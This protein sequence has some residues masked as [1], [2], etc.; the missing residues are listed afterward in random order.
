MFQLKKALI[1]TPKQLKEG[2]GRYA[3]AAFGGALPQIVFDEAL[4]Y[5]SVGAA[6]VNKTLTDLLSVCVT[7]A[8][9]AYTVE[10]TVC[11]TDARFQDLPAEAYFLKT[12]EGK[13]TL[14]GKDAAGA[15]YALMTFSQMVFMDG[16]TLTVPQAEIL[17]YPDFPRRG[18]SI[19]SRYGTELMTKDEWFRLIDYFSALKQNDVEIVI[20]NC[21]GLQ[22][23][24]VRT[25]CLYVPIKKYP[26]LKTPKI[27]K[28]YSVKEKKWVHEEN[29]LPPMFEE[30]FFGELVA[31]AKERNVTVRPFVNSLGHNSLIP[32]VFPEISA[33]KE[34]GEPANKGFCTLN[35]KTYEV[36]FSIYDEII[37]RYLLPNGVTEMHV[38]LDEVTPKYRCNCEKCKAH[39]HKDLMLDYMIR[40]CK[41]L[42]EKGMKRVFMCFDMLF[43]DFNIVN[44]ELKQ[45]FIDEDIYDVVVLD[46]WAYQDPIHLFR[47]RA[48]EVNSLFRSSIKAYTGYYHWTL[49][50]DNN[51]N[52]RACVKLAKKLGFEAVDAY[53]SWEDCQDKNYLTLADVSWNTDNADNAAEF[54][55][56]YAFRNYPHNIPGALEAFR[57]MYGIMIDETREAYLN[58]A[59][60]HLDYYFYCYQNEDAPGIKNFPGSAY[61]YIEERKEDYLPYLRYLKEKAS[62]ALEFFENSGVSSRMNDIWRLSAWQYYVLADEYLTLYNLHFSYNKGEADAHTVIRELERLITQREALMLLAENTRMEATKPTY[63]RNMSVFRQFMTDLLS[64]FRRELAAGRTP[65]LDM[66]DLTYAT[67]DMLTFLQ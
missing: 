6:Y 57:A 11:P 1:P 28:Y 43:Y 21:W 44:E 22:Y 34:S 23:D 48:D 42:K 17:D 13:A 60:W 40:V 20:Y 29:I 15:Y 4:P 38:G 37:D 49:P 39:E 64:Y 32:T 59:I 56:R 52:I 67:G 47:D 36:M 10:I 33:L 66:F 25:E 55:E 7:D 51:D 54:D 45:R 62:V 65:K 30:D 35:E 50:G 18:P 2:E 24:G 5:L 14:V 12:E 63:L 27:K 3:V 46:W 58:R 41:H 31:Y 16:D 53:S 26:Q 9:P 19:E 61:K 8:A